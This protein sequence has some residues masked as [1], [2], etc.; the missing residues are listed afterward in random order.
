MS[1][2]VTPWRDIDD[3]KQ[4][5]HELQA[6]DRRKDEFLAI[7]AHELRNPLAP[8]L[9]AVRVLGAA[10]APEDSLERSRGIM[11]RQVKTM[12]RLLDDLL[13]VS[14]IKQRKLE[15]RK[16]TV[17]LWTVLGNAIETSRPLIDA[18]QHKLNVTL[19]DEPL[20]MHLDPV[21]L[22][23]VVANLLNNA[24]KYTPPSGQ[25]DLVVTAEADKVRIAVKD[26][27]LGMTDDSL[28]HV[29][30]LF[31]KSRR[32]ALNRKAGWALAC[33]LLKAWWNST[34]VR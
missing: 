24:A 7:L 19:P 28:A 20:P 1:S 22:S 31:S 32:A 14:R 2:S 33:H 21:R 15:L 26:S 18:R 30:E 12:A 4:A 17:L 13:D 3:V 23:Q 6:V 10:D 9:T 8:I 34:A 27:G 5:R 16:E 11:E 29:F 25:I